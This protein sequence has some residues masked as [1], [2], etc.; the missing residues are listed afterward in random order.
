M[1]EMNNKILYDLIRLGEEVRLWL[2]I[3]KLKKDIISTI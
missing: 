2:L 3:L 1:L